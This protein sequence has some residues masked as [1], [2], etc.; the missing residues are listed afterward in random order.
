[1]RF[2]L[3][4]RNFKS[5]TVDAALR[6]FDAKP[7]RLETDE[8]RLVHARA[9]LKEVATIY[10]VPVPVVVIDPESPGLAVYIPE[11]QVD[12]LASSDRVPAHIVLSKWSILSLFHAVRIHLLALG[13]AEPV[14]PSDPFGWSCSLFYAAKP[15]MFRAR[16]R[17]R[18]VMGVNPIDTY[19]SD[20]IARM[21]ALGIINADDEVLI[22]RFDPRDLPAL[23]RGE[24]RAADILSRSASS[25]TVSTS[26][27]A[28]AVLSDIEVEAG[29][30]EAQSFLS[31]VA[32]GSD[33][34]LDNLGIA[35]LRRLSRGVF[36]GGYSLPKQALIERLRQHGIR[37]SRPHGG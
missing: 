23:E 3:R 29:I 16:A 18:R 21:R 36:S 26:A 12:S 24:L 2:H 4:F 22:P 20:S 31:S 19:S 27:T 32:E 10:G 17:E 11:E 6:L 35:E 8:E 13:V 14:G 15:V 9:F 37:A 30:Q 7:W 28:T 34:G 1:M 25:L 5:E 33:D